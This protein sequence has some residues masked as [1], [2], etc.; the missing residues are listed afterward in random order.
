MRWLAQ[1]Q[2]LGASAT[3]GDIHTCREVRGRP[4]ERM[5]PNWHYTTV[6]IKVNGSWIQKRHST[7]MGSRLSVV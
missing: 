7:S 4:D 3:S 5:L 2:R 1:G 6:R